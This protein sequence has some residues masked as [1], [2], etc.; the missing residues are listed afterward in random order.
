MQVDSRTGDFDPQVE[1][2]I[3]YKAEETPA[4]TVA[5]STL[6]GRAFMNWAHFP[7]T[8]SE[9]L[10]SEKRGYVVVFKDMGF[11]FT[12]RRGQYSPFAVVRLNRD[13]TLA[14]MSFADS[15]P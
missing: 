15:Q 2:R 6:L 11:E 12:D 1:P 8:E 5:K 9:A 14:D 13:L 10:Q 3:H 7:I 4:T